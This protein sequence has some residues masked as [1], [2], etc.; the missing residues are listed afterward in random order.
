[1]PNNRNINMQSD[2]FV[3]ISQKG[4]CRYVLNSR[5]SSWLFQTSTMLQDRECLQAAEERRLLRLARS[6]I[7]LNWRLLYPFLIDLWFNDSLTKQNPCEGMAWHVWVRK[8]LRRNRRKYKEVPFFLWLLFFVWPRILQIW[9]C[10]PG[11][12]RWQ[13]HRALHWSYSDNPD[14]PWPDDQLSRLAPAQF[15][16][17]WS[18][19]QGVNGVE[20]GYL[21]GFLIDQWFTKTFGFPLSLQT[22]HRHP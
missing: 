10:L 9:T 18:G 11:L 20:H 1:M 22:N 2:C 8:Q 12:A 5:V 6:W 17:A 4:S 19:C 13:C 7:I 16:L 3:L 14:G 21:E 15:F